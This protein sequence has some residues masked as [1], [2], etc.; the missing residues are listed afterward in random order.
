LREITG[1]ERAKVSIILGSDEARSL[2]PEDAE[3]LYDLS[4]GGRRSEN[5]GVS[6]GHEDVENS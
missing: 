1:P 4:A 3:R 5:I 6:I 2:S